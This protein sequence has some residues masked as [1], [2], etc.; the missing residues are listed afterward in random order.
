MRDGFSGRCLAAVW[1]H[2]CRVE[3]QARTYKDSSTLGLGVTHCTKATMGLIEKTK[4][5]LGTQK[6]L[7]F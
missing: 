2:R 5:T 6:S 4:H 1:S 7:F 3:L